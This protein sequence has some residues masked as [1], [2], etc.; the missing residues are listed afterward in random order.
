MAFSPLSALGT[1]VK[2]FW[3]GLDVV[4]RFTFNLIFLFFLIIFIIALVAGAS[5]TVEEK[6]ALI[7]DLKGALV[8]QHSGSVRDSLLAEAQGDARKSTQLR[9]ILAVLDAAG[10][11]NKISS[12]VLLLDNM[13]S[14]G[15]STLREV[16]T[17][18]DRF[19]ASGKKVVAWGT[20]YDQKQYFLAA[21]ANE[22]YLHPMGTVMLTG[23]G[24]YR[25]YYHDALEKIGVTVNVLKVGTYK[26]FAEPF[27]ANGPS[28]AAAEAESFLYSAL[29][30]IYTDDVEK[31]RKLADGSIMDSIDHLPELLKAENGD[32]AKMALKLKLVDGLK[33]RDELRTLMLERGAK[34]TQ[35]KSF[36]QI[37]LD[38]YLAL[39]KPQLF[40]D[41][42]G[43]VIAEGEISDGMAPPGSIGGL[44]TANLVR[45]A[46][47]DD[48]IKAVVLRV[49]S[50]GGS[51]LGSELIRRELELTKKAGKPVIVSMGDVAA[52]GGYWISM[53]SD[54]V[55]ADAATITGSIG[56]FAIFP[57]VDRVIDK[58]GIHTA[59][60]TTTWLSDA[61]NP[62][63]PLDP[64]F[65][66]VIQ[67][68]INHVYSEFTSKA[69]VARKT[70][71]EK[72]NDVAQGRVWTGLQAKE[73][74]LIDR[75]GGFDDAIK[76]AATRAKLKGDYRITYIERE[77]SGIDRVLSTFGGATA[78]VIN[79]QFKLALVP[80]GLP[81][82]VAQDITKDLGWL[83]D[84]QKDKKG[85]TTIA[86]CFCSMP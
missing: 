47:E 10:K 74:G 75:I 3:H 13:Q 76:S 49:D 17:A 62:L 1:G 53:S 28:P 61:F 41:E 29:W 32:I 79:D 27:I 63:R 56:V 43:V 59:G 50:P 52:S 85:Y 14:A 73:R 65:G 24:H 81:V 86:H 18:I 67:S 31:A 38:D 39:Q 45:K 77:P 71:P 44:S 57:T 66:D 21:H 70:T 42:I 78:K 11:D 15:L 51:V 25:N 20:N 12:V 6:T 54:E 30:K 23:F 19:K 58:L 26:S 33:T 46:R 60:T 36:R 68:G 22:V 4:R 7:L 48:K 64:R 34:D 72:I 5:R 37:D 83:T 84:L 40:G 2:Y 82:N 35:T 55:I 69:A 80:T 16:A 8:E 9:D